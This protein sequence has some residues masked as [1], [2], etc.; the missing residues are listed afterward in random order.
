MS[1][2]KNTR[3]SYEVADNGYVFVIT[4]ENIIEDGKVISAGPNHRRPILPD[5]DLSE[6]D[7]NTK[8]ICDAAF[9]EQVKADYAT[10][11]AEAEARRAEEARIAE[12]ARKADEAAAN[13]VEEPV[14]EPAVTE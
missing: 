1:L 11:Q 3:T 10:K 13:A 9:T 8:A 5:A 2:E 14:E 7:A 4:Q 12:E 6:E